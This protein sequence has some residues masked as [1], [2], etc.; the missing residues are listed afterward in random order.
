MGTYV[1]YV[2][3]RYACIYFPIRECFSLALENWLSAISK[4]T[5]AH[6]AIHF[7][8]NWTFA[9]Q[10]K[11]KVEQ[12]TRREWNTTNSQRKGSQQTARNNSW[13][14]SWRSRLGRNLGS[15]GCFPLSPHALLQKIAFSEIKWDHMRPR[16]CYL[17]FF[18]RET[19]CSTVCLL[20]TGRFGFF[21]CLAVCHSSRCKAHTLLMPSNSWADTFRW[22][23]DWKGKGWMWS[24]LK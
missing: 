13:R 21:S 6:L 22:L 12:L 5:P 23:C 14:S 2:A 8:L 19:F 20:R 18:P 1:L 24:G 11:I 16:F 7:L 3:F 9:K 4:L 10:T 17:F 15:W